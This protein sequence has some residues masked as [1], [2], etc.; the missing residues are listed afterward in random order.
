[1]DGLFGRS[2][3]YAAPRSFPRRG[4]PPLGQRLCA[5]D[6][7]AASHDG[8]RVRADR[9]QAGA[10][11]RDYPPPGWRPEAARPTPRSRV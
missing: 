10:R 5:R 1:V 7:G 4:L 3:G 6:V 2:R 9:F 11:G 8:A